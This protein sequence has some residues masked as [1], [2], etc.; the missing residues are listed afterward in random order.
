MEVNQENVDLGN[1]SEHFLSHFCHVR[2]H[3]LFL[4]RIPLCICLLRDE[5]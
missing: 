5:T 3:S 4:L 2:G 1:E